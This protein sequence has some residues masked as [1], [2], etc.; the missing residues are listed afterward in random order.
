MDINQRIYQR[1]L[2]QD[3]AFA[4]L[5]NDFEKIGR[6]NDINIKGLALTYLSERV[7][8]VSYSDDSEV[9]IF[10]TGNRFYVQKVPCKIIYDILYPKPDKNHRIMTRRCGLRFGKLSKN[11]LELLELFLKNY[12]KGSVTS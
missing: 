1:F 4:A 2:V 3:D 12:T 10:L 7:K 6:V 9:E 11:Q 8:K 5:G